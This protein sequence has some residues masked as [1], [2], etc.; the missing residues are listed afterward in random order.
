MK[1]R[2]S[3]LGL[4]LVIVVV[5]VV[6]VNIRTSKL[7]PRLSLGVIEVYADNESGSSGLDRCTEAGGYC[8]VGRIKYWGITIKFD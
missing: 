5:I 7:S 2:I 4:I 8:F 6:N 1:R 3:F